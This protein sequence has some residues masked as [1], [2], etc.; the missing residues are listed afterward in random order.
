MGA[1]AGAGATGRICGACGGAVTTKADKRTSIGIVRTA[2]KNSIKTKVLPFICGRKYGRQCRVLYRG[3]QKKLQCFTMNDPSKRS[4]LVCAAA[5]VSKK[6]IGYKLRGEMD[7]PLG[8]HL[9]L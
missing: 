6:K 8:L 4:V 1:G 2:Q 5:P 3:K 9:S 7:E